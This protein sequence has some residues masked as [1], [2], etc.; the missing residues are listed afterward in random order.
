[1]MKKMMMIAAMMAATLSANAQNQEAGDMYVRPMVGATLSTI[2]GEHADNAKMKIGL[3]GGAEFGYHVTNQFALT[4]GLLV[5]MQGSK[6]EDTQLWRDFK[7]TL[8]YLNV[9]I[10]ANYYIVKG[11]AIKA[12]IQPGFMLSLKGKGQAMDD[13]GWKDYESTS[14][15][16]A[17]KFDLSIPMGLSYEFN[18]FV[19][20][21]RYNLGLLSINKD[22]NL[23]Q[24]NGVI[25]V[26]LGYK[27]PL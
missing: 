13:F 16:D 10:M 7:T 26:T 20:D 25:M 2:T 5:S 9:P 27:I 1:M 4:G 8:T 15:E 17:K 6:M 22:S 3:V 19:I 21:A 23:K 18:D 24:K 12:G 14:T 11:L